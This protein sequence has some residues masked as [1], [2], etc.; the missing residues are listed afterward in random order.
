MVFLVAIGCGWFVGLSG[1][2]AVEENMSG[3]VSVLSN[4]P[5]ADDV[6]SGCQCDLILIRLDK[7]LS[8]LC[9]D[10]LLSMYPTKKIF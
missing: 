3:H 4:R 2:T 6:D 5:L 1:L 10:R 9:S 7:L 8:S